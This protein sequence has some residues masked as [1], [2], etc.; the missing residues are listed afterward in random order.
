METGFVV[1]IAIVALAIGVAIGI[2]ITNFRKK[3]NGAYG[4]IYVYYDDSKISPTLLLDCGVNID[5][6]AAQKQ[7]AFNVIVI[8]QDSRK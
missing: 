4:D 7:V 8:H 3:K 5:D 6:I 2:V 1:L